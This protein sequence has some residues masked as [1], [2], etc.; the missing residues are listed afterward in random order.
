MIAAVDD[1]LRRWFIDRITVLRP[2]P[3][4]AVVAEQVR[5]QPPDDGWRKHV[6]GLGSLKALNVYLVDVRENRELR[7]TE[8]IRRREGGLLVEDPPALR[9]DCHYLISAWSPASEDAE[10]TRDE[11]R[12]LSA[13]I[14]VLVDASPLVPR[15]V[16]FPDPVPDK[17]PAALTDAE[18][19]FVLA[20]PGGFPKLAEFWGTMGGSSPWKP[21]VELVVTV[22]IL[23][24]PRPA[25]PEVTTRTARYRPGLDGGAAS[26]A[27]TQIAGRVL[28]TTPG[29]GAPDP[30]ADA[31][32]RLESVAGAALSTARTDAGGRF[33][34]GGLAAGSYQ[35][36]CRA[37]GHPEAVRADIEV[38]SLSGEYDLIFPQDG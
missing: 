5:F 38:P 13:L 6:S 19:P 27:Y 28:Q 37:Q 20:S 35:L 36:R 9:L 14:Q 3:E 25:G 11:H 4:I 15:A 29:G 2:K 24:E 30:V 18:L 22:P 23:R 7:S 21:V 17:F 10:R 12:V 34:F 16:F 33:T 1:V 8:G 26:E 32:V 31:W